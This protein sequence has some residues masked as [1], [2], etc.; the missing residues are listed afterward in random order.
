MKRTRRFGWLT[1]AILVV[2]AVALTPGIRAY[3]QERGARETFPFFNWDLFSRVPKPEQ[4]SYGFRFTAIDGQRLDAPTYFEETL[5]PAHQ[6]SPAQ[7]MIGVI[8]GA[9]ERGD[10]T[11]VERYRE[12]W[13]SR[14][15]QPLTSAS[16]ELV[17][18]EFTIEERYECDCFTS[19]VVLAE[20][21]MG[22][23]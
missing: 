19:E 20:F 13:E 6:S 18:R 7:I 9:H 5:L 15:L 2:Y 12:V 17:R 1:V 22:Q 10:A 4:V 11:T 23:P 16:Y 8:G 14:Y 3:T 21:T